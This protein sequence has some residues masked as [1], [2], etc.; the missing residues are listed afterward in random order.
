MIGG[1]YDCMKYIITE[2]RLNNF[3]LKYINEKYPV[4]EI[5]YGEGYD[6]DGNPDYSSYRF[7]FGGY[8]DDEYEGNIFEWYD[9]DYWD[10]DNPLAKSRI[11]ESPILFFDDLKK[12]D[13]M[14]GEH[15]KPV[16]KKW[17]LDNFGLEIKTFLE[18]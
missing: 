18:W 5:N 12:M 3:I 6:D 4:D 9:K 7:Y 15:W 1:I 11:E 10:G 8:D 13:L 16:F 17:F 2:N 14:F